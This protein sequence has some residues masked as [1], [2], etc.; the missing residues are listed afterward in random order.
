MHFRKITS[1]DFGK[2]YGTKVF[3]TL[4]ASIS[5]PVLCIDRSFSESLSL[6]VTIQNYMKSSPKIIKRDQVGSDY[7]FLCLAS[8]SKYERPRLD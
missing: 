7:I 5:D 8:L 3:E 4:I 2:F 6:L 1:N